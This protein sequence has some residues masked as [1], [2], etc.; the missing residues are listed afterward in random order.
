MPDPALPPSDTADLRALTGR[1]ETLERRQ[2]MIP[3]VLPFAVIGG[4]PQDSGYQSTNSASYTEI[5]RTDFYV[6]A[7]YLDYDLQMSSI[8]AT[9]PPT[10]MEWKVTAFFRNVAIPTTILVSGSDSPGEPQHAGFVDLFA[11]A[12]LGQQVL[13]EF[14]S[15]RLAIKRTGGSGQ[16]AA[17]R[18][19]KPW[20]IRSYTT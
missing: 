20:L 18:M 9:T 10:T 17:V 4:V 15:L 19:V 12:G 16:A 2:Q 13:T 3:Q 11:T 14:V 7:R 5:T 1:V 8:Y 6:T